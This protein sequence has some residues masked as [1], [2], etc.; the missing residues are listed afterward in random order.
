MGDRLTNTSTGWQRYDTDGSKSLDEEEFVAMTAPVVQ[1]VSGLE[2]E[3]YTS[4]ADSADTGRLHRPDA[5]GDEE[6]DLGGRRSFVKRQPRRVAAWLTR[7]V[8]V[9]LSLPT[10][11][12][13][14]RPH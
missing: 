8:S 1:R 10:S 3:A 4:H 5:A 6:Q 12:G 14:R 2:A 13:W 11:N 9:A 7:S